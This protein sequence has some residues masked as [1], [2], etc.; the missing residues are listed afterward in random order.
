MLL[1]AWRG[2]RVII[3]CCLDN[4]PAAAGMVEAGRVE[5]NLGA[6]VGRLGPR[7]GPGAPETVAD[8]GS[9]AR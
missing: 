5:E 8:Q 1:Q 2:H 7:V 3:G 9:P 4:Q 6:L